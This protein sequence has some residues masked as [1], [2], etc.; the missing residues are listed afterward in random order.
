MKKTPTEL[1][2]EAIRNRVRRDLNYQDAS[3]NVALGGLACT[4]IDAL[5][6]ELAMCKVALHEVDFAYEPGFPVLRDLS[7]VMEAGRTT[8]LVGATGSGKTTVVKLMFRFYDIDSGS[9]TLDDVDIRKLPLRDLRTAFGLVSQDVFLFHGTVA[10]NIAYG[11]PQATHAEI[12]HAAEMMDR[13][14]VDHM[15]DRLTGTLAGMMRVNLKFAILFVSYLLGLTL[16]FS[17][18]LLISAFSM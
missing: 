15:G 16:I 8:A 5:L 13:Y 17:I 10:A 6:K 1:N 2:A 12:R 3:Q 14:V 11:R 18:T 7:I 4:W 9:I